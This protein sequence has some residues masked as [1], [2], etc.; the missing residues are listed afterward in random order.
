MP[1]FSTTLSLRSLVEGNIKATHPSICQ[2]WASEE[3]GPVLQPRRRCLC[4]RCENWASSEVLPAS[5]VLY[6]ISTA[7]Y[8]LQDSDAHAH[9]EVDGGMGGAA[10]YHLLMENAC[11]TS[12]EISMGSDSSINHGREGGE[13]HRISPN[14]Y[15]P[16]TLFA[17]CQIASVVRAPVQERRRARASTLFPRYHRLVPELPLRGRWAQNPSGR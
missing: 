15:L 3:S 2:G 1:T 9:V 7:C 6:Y 13:S 8:D 4:H 11:D 5:T 14:S 16:F 17:G 12:S 10:Q